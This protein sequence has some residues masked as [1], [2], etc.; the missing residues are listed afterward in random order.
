MDGL[1]EAGEV[2]LALCREQRE[3]RRELRDAVRTLLAQL[4]HERP[5]ELLRARQ[6]PLHAPDGAPLDGLMVAI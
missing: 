1:A 2:A 3:L 4:R 5:G 6:R